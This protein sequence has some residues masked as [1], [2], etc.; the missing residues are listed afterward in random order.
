MPEIIDRIKAIASQ[1]K[2]KIRTLSSKGK[3][4]QFL[5]LQLHDQIL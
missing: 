3:S 4:P 5:P 1:N 2:I